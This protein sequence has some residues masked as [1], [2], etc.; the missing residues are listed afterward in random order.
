[1]SLKLDKVSDLKL[2]LNQPLPGGRGF[3][4]QYYADIERLCLEAIKPDQPQSPLWKT[5]RYSEEDR[6]TLFEIVCEEVRDSVKETA[7]DW[8][9]NMQ[10]LETD[11]Y[12]LD[13]EDLQ[14]LHMMNNPPEGVTMN[15]LEDQIQC[16][17][18]GAMAR[19]IKWGYV[20]EHKD[21]PTLRITPQ[22]IDLLQ[23]WC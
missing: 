13:I 2:L 14:A 10:Q 6:Q 19:A 8:L 16:G 20:S 9:N 4:A 23:E 22:G 1:M 12:L 18:T 11:G 17:D 5:D 15:E 21:A 3:Q 7:E